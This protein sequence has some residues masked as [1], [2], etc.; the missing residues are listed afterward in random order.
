MDKVVR[1]FEKVLSQPNIQ[2]QLD[3]VGVPAGFMGPKE[4][5][6]LVDEEYKY[7]MELYTKLER[8]RKK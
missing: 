3:K 8:E 5:A 4:F 2:A 1:A 7:Y 6:N